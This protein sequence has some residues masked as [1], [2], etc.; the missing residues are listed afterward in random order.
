M[1]A[2]LLCRII[3]NLKAVRTL[4]RD[5]LPMEAATLLRSG[6]EST[7]WLGAV[8]REQ[9]FLDKVIKQ[10]NQSRKSL[11][12]HVLKHPFHVSQLSVETVEAVRQRCLNKNPDGGLGYWKIEDVAAAAG[13]EIFYPSYVSLST[14]SAHPSAASLDKHATIRDDEVIDIALVPKEADWEEVI[15]LAASLPMFA[16]HF[17]DE[18]FPRSERVWPNRLW[19]RYENLH[20]AA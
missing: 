14:Q 11:A 4:Q 8:T 12:Q 15:S 1:W 13:M 5:N 19:A 9:S 3:T 10:D 18:L 20:K 2:C 16:G 7:F 17:L 6:L